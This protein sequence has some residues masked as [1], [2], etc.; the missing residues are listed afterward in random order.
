MQQVSP[1]Q[2]DGYVACL[3]WGSWSQ[4]NSGPPR[5][6]A[7]QTTLKWLSSGFFFHQNMLVFS[8][9]SMWLAIFQRCLSYVVLFY[10]FGLGLNIP[11]HW[12]LHHMSCSAKRICRPIMKRVFHA[13]QIGCR[14]HHLKLVETLQI[15]HCLNLQYLR[16]PSQ[17]SMAV[18]HFWAFSA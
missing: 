6:V 13:W 1:L 16:A 14:Q 9:P 18:V 2:Q 4:T 11:K 12:S 3:S 5:V 7:Y 17:T 10:S 8:T 15:R